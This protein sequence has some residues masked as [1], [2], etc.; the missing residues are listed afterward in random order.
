MN[1]LVVPRLV[2]GHQLVIEYCRWW[3]KFGGP[4]CLGSIE[5]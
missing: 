3:L 5:R 2:E 1:Q 4:V